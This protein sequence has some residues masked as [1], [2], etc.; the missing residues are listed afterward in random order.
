M[1]K[2]IVAN[3]EITMPVVDK[4]FAFEDTVKAYEYLESRAH[5]GKVV[6]RVSRDEAGETQTKR[7][8][9]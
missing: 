1:N 5:V 2:L 3:P 9:L 8:I 4:V 6:V 7:Y